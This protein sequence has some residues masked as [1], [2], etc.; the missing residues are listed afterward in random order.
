MNPQAP[1]SPNPTMP[2]VSQPQ[3]SQNVALPPMAS[4]DAGQ[5]Q[6][7]IGQ[8]AAA[9]IQPAANFNVAT[10]SVAP[11]TMNAEE[12]KVWVNKAGE[13]IRTLRGDPFNESLE[14]GKLKA[15]YLKARYG[16]YI[17]T[18]DDSRQ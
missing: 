17:K 15:A 8:M 6:Q 10:S 7:P 4:N 5:W 14:L 3:P 13:I 12:D 18:G 9:P 2:Q 16:K 11:E 1:I